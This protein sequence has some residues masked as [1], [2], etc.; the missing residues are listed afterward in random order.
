MTT[1]LSAEIRKAVTEAGEEPL[2]IIDPETQERYM[3]LKAEVFERLWHLLQ[4]GPLSREEQ[5]YL[6][7]QA[8]RRAGWDDPEMDI[9]DDLAHS[10]PRGSVNS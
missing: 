10:T 2:E 6:L 5:K 4:G 3:L 7:E 9:Y 8:G 1:T